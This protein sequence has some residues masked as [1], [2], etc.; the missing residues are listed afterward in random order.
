MHNGDS[1]P[2]APKRNEPNHH[3]ANTASAHRPCDSSYCA[4]SPA[5]SASNSSVVVGRLLGA[6][7]DGELLGGGASSAPPALGG[8]GMATG[9]FEARGEAPVNPGAGRAGT[10][11]L[12]WRLLPEPSPPPAARRRP[13]P[14]VGEP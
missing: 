11:G 2:F 8:A 6:L 10:A 7:A 9:V 13:L 3:H 1:S 12:C 5:S 14:A 4:R